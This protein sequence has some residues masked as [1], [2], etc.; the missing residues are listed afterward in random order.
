MILSLALFHP[1]IVFRIENRTRKVRISK[2]ASDL[3]SIIIDQY[4]KGL[5]ISN[6]SK[7]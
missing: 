2:Y 5:S 6:L 1:L 7:E 3:K 4:R